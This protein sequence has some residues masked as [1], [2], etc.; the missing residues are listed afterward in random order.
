[1]EA[2]LTAIELTGTID[3]R[4]QLQLDD[5]LPIPGPKRVR[6]IVLYSPVDEWGET[7]WRHA[8]AHNPAFDFLK[9][10]EEDIYSLADGK[11]FHAEA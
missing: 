10:P 6:V 8:A 7:E 5:L 2:A 4:R 1:M 3:E 9:E 11:P